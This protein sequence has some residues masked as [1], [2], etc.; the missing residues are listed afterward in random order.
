LIV[1]GGLAGRRLHD[2]IDGGPAVQLAAA[3]VPVAGLLC[4]CPVSLHC[5]VESA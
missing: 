1:P 5:T 3:P 4:D 2:A